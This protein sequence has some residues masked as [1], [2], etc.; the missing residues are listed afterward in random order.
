[1]KNIW[2][3]LTNT[4]FSNTESI[5]EH[6]DICIIGGGFTGVYS[7]LLLASHGHQVALFE[8]NETLGQAATGFST[9][10]LTIQ[11]G[12]IYQKLSEELRP[13]YVLEHER[14]IHTL[15]DQLPA[16]LINACTSYLYSETPSSSQQL[17]DEFQ[18]YKQLQLNCF[19]T[20]E[21]E[22][23][24]QVDYAIAL[25]GQ[26]QINPYESLL[27][28]AEEAVRNGA[29]IFTNSR[30]Q[31]IDHESQTIQVANQT[32]NFQN[33]I[34]ATHY[35]IDAIPALQFT[36]LT[37]FRSYLCAAPIASPLE[38]QYL[39]VG[40]KARTIR[41]AT[42]QDEY[43][44][45]YGGKSHLAGNA[46]DTEACYDLLTQEM[47]QYFEVQSVPFQWSNQ[48]VE[49]FDSLPL[50][51]RVSARNENIY[52]ATGYNKWG[53]SQSLVAANILLYTI[54]QE[55]HPLQQYYTP[56]RIKPIQMLENATYM[57]GQFL[58][59]YIN[60]SNTPICTHLG[61]HTRWNEADKS[62]DCPCHGSRFTQDGRIING[63]AVEPLNMETPGN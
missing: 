45:L 62:W 31:H 52:I 18:Y 4:Q 12:A 21:T 5:K 56:S 36:K 33:L 28:L 43:Y 40:E 2:T 42:I 44:I 27:F 39:A 57:V 34:V 32:V 51:G 7:A 50:V 35:P 20:A 60:R 58:N 16:H 25:T 53:L 8:A 11:H 13:L 41:T 55:V 54:Q 6:Y 49:T 63:P 38:G 26:F 3:T 30:V 22:L 19:E 48:D 59:G 10:K 24:F 23:P 29:T 1:M 15:A 17:K 14:A 61:C 9:G 46:T 47:K 37:N